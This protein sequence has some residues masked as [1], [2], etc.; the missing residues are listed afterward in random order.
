MNQ[1]ITQH[2][3]VNTILGLGVICKSSETWN[4]FK[5]SWRDFDTFDQFNPNRLCDGHSHG[6]M[7]EFQKF[8]SGPTTSTTSYS[9]SETAANPRHNII[10]QQ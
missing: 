9:L 5:F 2:G 1:W 10:Q 6:C 8:F 4:R 7:I 3:G